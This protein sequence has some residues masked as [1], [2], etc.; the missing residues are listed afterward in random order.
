M[1][2]IV[3]VEDDPGTRMLIA[4]VLKKEG[5]DVLTADNGSQ[6]M[7]VIRG[8]RPD[9]ILSDVEMAPMNGFEL[10]AAIRNDP[11]AR[12]TPV[13]L[14]TSLHERAH[15]RIGMTSGAD[16]YLTKPFRASEL[17]DAVLAQ[18]GK[19]ELQNAIQAAALDHAVQKAL[20]AHTHELSRVYDGVWPPR[21]M[22][23]GLRPKARKA[24]KPLFR[25]ASLPSPSTTIPFCQSDCRSISWP[26]WSSASTAASATRSTSLAHGIC[27]FSGAGWVPYLLTATTRTPSPTIFGRSGRRS[28]SATLRAVC[29]SSPNLGWTRPRLLVLA[30]RSPFTMGPC[31][32]R[33][34]KTPCM[35][36]HHRPSRWGRQQPPPCRSIATSRNSGGPS[37][38]APVF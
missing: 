28:A 18:L 35:M 22:S 17:R 14:L 30:S 8:R 2:L 1:A 37:A 25:A 11:V 4:S 5:H 26:N 12:G 34:C 16:D 27:R 31:C 13:I 3:V 9:L 21:W 6:G 32:W 7:A 24:T 38:P 10:L 19:R 33:P 36:R 23:A 20:E 29:A 15:I